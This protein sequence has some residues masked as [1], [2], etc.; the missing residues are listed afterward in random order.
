MKKQIQE[1]SMVK[2]WR[3][4]LK[5]FVL[6]VFAVFSIQSFAPPTGKKGSKFGGVQIGVITYSYRS[7]PDNSLTSVLNYFVLYM[8]GE[9]YLLAK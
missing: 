2:F 4:G 1:K 9:L 5:V 6:L 8:E 3:T 7:M